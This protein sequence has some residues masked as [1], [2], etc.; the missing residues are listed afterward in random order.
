MI[1]KGGVTVKKQVLTKQDIQR[2]LLIKINKSKPLVLFLT[3]LTAIFMPAYIVF[4]INYSDIMIEYRTGHLAGRGYPPLGLFLGLIAILFLTVFLLNYYYIDLYK[5]KKGKF[6]VFE[7]KLYDRKRELI[8]YY[9]RTAQE[10]SLY[11]RSGRVAVDDDVYSYSTVGDHFYVVR[12]R[13]R[14]TPLLAYH[15]KYYEISGN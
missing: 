13:A 2:E 15:T 6:I 14:K 11:F 7:E 1:M 8:R 4:V 10:N 5:A 3:V 12:L 9:R